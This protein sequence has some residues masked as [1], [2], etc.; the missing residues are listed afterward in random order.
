MNDDADC[1]TL[2]PPPEIPRDFR[3]L[4]LESRGF[5]EPIWYAISILS[6]YNP[7]IWRTTVCGGLLTLPPHERSWIY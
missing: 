3:A 6:T 7:H 1:L 4:G 5:R 2:R